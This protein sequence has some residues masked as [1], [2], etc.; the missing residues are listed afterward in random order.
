MLSTVPIKEIN[1]VAGVVSVIKPAL[2]P[3]VVTLFALLIVKVPMRVA[4][5]MRP[6]IEILFVPA[7]RVRLFEPSMAFEKIISPVPVLALMDILP[8]K[9]T[10][11]PKVTAPFVVVI[12]LAARTEPRPLCVNAPVKVNVAAED[13]VSVLTI[14]KLAP[15]PEVALRVLLNVAFCDISERPEE[16]FK[17][18]APLNVVIPVP[19]N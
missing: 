14:C 2:I 3:D 7:V 6:A 4:D 15:P 16:L 18:T 13:S 9:V 19:A 11:P 8:L 17:S 5:P 1:P 10:A 12:E